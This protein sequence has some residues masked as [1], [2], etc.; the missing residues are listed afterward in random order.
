MKSL[1]TIKQDL[2]TDALQQIRSIGGHNPSDA[3][4]KE[5]S[6]SNEEDQACKV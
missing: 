4:C 1:T 5:E 2:C 6:T 3:D